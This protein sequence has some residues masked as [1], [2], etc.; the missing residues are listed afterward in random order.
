[1]LQTRSIVAGVALV[2]AVAGCRDTAAPDKT[3][4]VAASI[5]TPPQGIF[6]DT[7]NGP[8][9]TCS[10]PITI[11]AQGTGSA[12]G[13]WTGATEFWFYGL[14][15]TNPAATTTNPAS[16]LQQAFGAPT[17]AA[18]E[19]KHS[20]WTFHFGAPFEATMRLEYTLS[21]GQTA[22][23]TSVHFTCGPSVQGSVAPTVTQ[24]T[25]PSMTGELKVGDTVSVSFAA[26]GS[27]GI[28]ETIVDAS[29]HSSVS[30][31]S[32]STW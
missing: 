11:E 8:V 22:R 28:W 32:A 12:S 19:T 4:T 30:K 7:P 25:T 31:S 26:T 5:D 17:I 9:I 23:S 1:M 16:D 10:V 15:R 3:F 24:V 29:V 2:V 6:S 20:I 21:D 27:T 13:T 14:D 18:G